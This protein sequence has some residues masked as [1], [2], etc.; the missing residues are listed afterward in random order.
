MLLIYNVADKKYHGATFIK[1]KD[2]VIALRGLHNVAA[3]QERQALFLPRL[4]WSL[5][6]GEKLPLECSGLVMHRL[7]T[8]NGLAPGRRRLVQEDCALF[9][10][11][12]VQCLLC[13]A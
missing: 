10:Q 6:K 1:N 5:R 3:A 9:V 11:K 7:G 4:R 13:S 8:P 2:D 12:F